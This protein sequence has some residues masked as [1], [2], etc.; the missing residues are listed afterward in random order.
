MNGEPPASTIPIIKTDGDL[1]ARRQFEK[2]PDLV[3]EARVGMG[4]GNDLMDTISVSSDA[5]VS[6]RAV[7]DRVRGELGMATQPIIPVLG[8]GKRVRI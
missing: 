3:I 5:F 8:G 4:V 6:S 1:I 2:I 7:G